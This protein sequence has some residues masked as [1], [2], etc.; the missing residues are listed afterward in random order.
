MFYGCIGF[1]DG[2]L[3]RLHRPKIKSELAERYYTRRKKMYA[4]NN[5]LVIDRLSMSI[6]VTLDATTMSHPQRVGP[7]QGLA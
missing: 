7:V 3:V 2:T 1:I 4:M 6:R 5:T